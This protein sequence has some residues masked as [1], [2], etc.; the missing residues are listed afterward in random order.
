[1]ATVRELVT[2]WGFDIDD[3]PLK[4]MDRSI[5]GVKSSLAGMG[6]ALA[7]VGALVGGVFLR[8]AGIMEQSKIAFET[9]LG[10]ATKAQQLLQD[11]TKF[12]AATPFEIPELV[13]SSKKLLAFGFAAE[14]IIPTMNSLG[15]IAAGV[16]R[17]KLPQLI[18]ALGQVRAATK[19]RGQELRQFSEAGV[20]MIA[21][22]AKMRHV[23]ESEVSEMVSRGEITFEDTR[24][25]LENLTTGTGRFNN[26]MLKQ[27]K[28]L[29]GILS[30]LKDYFTVLSIEI[31][32]KL[33]PQVKEIVGG[34]YE[35]LD[36]NR[37]LVKEK[38]ARFVTMLVS[39][40]KDLIGILRGLLKG[41]GLLAKAFGGVENSIDFVIKAIIAFLALRLFTSLGGIIYNTFMIAKGFAA[42]GNAALIAQLKIM[43]IPVAIGLAIAAIGLIIEDIVAFFQGKDSITGRIVKQFQ[44]I[45]PK[46]MP[47]LSGLLNT[48]VGWIMSMGQQI[49][50]LF[51]G[52]INTFI[53]LFA[54]RFPLLYGFIKSY[55]DFWIAGFQLIV[56]AVSFLWSWMMKI[57][58][59]ANVVFIPAFAKVGE[60]LGNMFLQTIANAQNFFAKLNAIIAPIIGFFETWIDV[61]QR[62]FGLINSIVKSAVSPLLAG[63]MNSM[64]NAMPTEQIKSITAAMKNA[65]PTDQI[66]GAAGA[67]K[68]AIPAKQMAGAAAGVNAVLPQ[69]AAGMDT[70]V[71][72]SG[73]L[74]NSPLVRPASAQ[75]QNNT[76]SM[77]PAINVT[78]AGGTTNEHTGAVVAQSVKTALESM[79]R[80]AGRD[81]TPAIER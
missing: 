1:M 31:G 70:L 26:L 51:G 54:E 20:P 14:E 44:N 19:L 3:R 4:A 18:L 12:A 2:E 63:Y 57:A 60:F 49:I 8:Q 77:Q 39:A 45:A 50:D 56:G 55:V 74:A 7:G 78:V 73:Q 76:V 32:E 25:A 28:S 38:L 24:K 27:S 69:M 29:F 6:L 13:E 80:E 71:P 62:V 68:G 15:N 53:A 34:L 42:I 67:I 10:S 16:G 21:E 33:M 47:F 41:L 64:K 5:A 48:I 79:M 40:M 66:A 65:M 72:P 23:A 61:L 9:M 37:E 30:N 43:A 22:I 52:Y 58:E 46:I 59:V 35:W 36:A 81:L 17:E 75:V 11:I